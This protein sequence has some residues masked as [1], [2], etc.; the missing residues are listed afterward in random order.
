MI[1]M[2][3]SYD[4]TIVSSNLTGVSQIIAHNEEAYDY[5]VGEAN[6][7]VFRDG[8]APIFEERIGDFISDAGHAHLCCELV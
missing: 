8:S 2:T 1:Y 4:F 6:Y 5:L 7:L 3:T